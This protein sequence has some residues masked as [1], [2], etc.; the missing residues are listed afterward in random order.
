M[1]GLQGQLAR[2][3][4]HPERKS[5]QIHKRRCLLS[6]ALQVLA[7]VIRQEEEIKGIQIGKGVKLSLFS[8][9]V[10]FFLTDFLF[11]FLF[12]IFIYLF[13]CTGS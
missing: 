12:F 9:D 7:R 11:L 8:D 6:I 13:G 5:R 3:L 10:I 1:L 4:E 2:G